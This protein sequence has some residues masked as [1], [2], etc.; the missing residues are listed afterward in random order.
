MFYQ[1]VPKAQ[2]PDV[3]NNEVFK[4]F[5]DEN[6]QQAFDQYADYVYNNT[7]LLDSAKMNEMCNADN[8]QTL[9]N[10]PAVVHALSVVKNYK[11]YYEPKINEFNYEMFEL[12]RAYQGGFVREKQK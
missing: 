2:H 1:D 8:I 9:L 7:V 5:G 6:W 10:D 4:N 3:Y 12:N 11:T